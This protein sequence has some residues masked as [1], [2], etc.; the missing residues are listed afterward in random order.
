MV[1]IGKYLKTKRFFKELTM[2]QV[3]EIAKDKYNFSTSTSVLSAIETDKN[4]VVDGELLLV[5]SD[6]YG[7]DMNELRSLALE[8]IKKNGRKKRSNDN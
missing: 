5:L 6:M 2:R 8:D 1:T 4:R 7:F 3:V